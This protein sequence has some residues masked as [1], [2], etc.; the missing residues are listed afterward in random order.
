MRRRSRCGR[1]PIRSSRGHQTSPFPQSTPESA[2]V[3]RRGHPFDGWELTVV[4]SWRTADG[5]LRLWVELP[6]GRQR[7]MPAS[8]TSLEALPDDLPRPARPGG[9]LRD[10]A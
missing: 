1:A 4:R 3:V 10:F 8:W 7:A 9:G 2:R 5:Q 6:D